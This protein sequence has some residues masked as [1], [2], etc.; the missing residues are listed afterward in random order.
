MQYI[1]LIVGLPILVGLFMVKNI[2][3][4]P[5]PIQLFI[6]GAKIL[7]TIAVVVALSIAI[8][9]AIV[10]NH[11]TNTAEIELTQKLNKIDSLA[12]IENLQIDSLAKIAIQ[13]Q[14][15]K[16]KYNPYAIGTNEY[17]Q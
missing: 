4:L 2:A 11:N 7:I 9:D 16:K 5:L 13:N 10:E 8:Y 14:F 17:Y 3:S 15:P 6:K 1:I 12:K